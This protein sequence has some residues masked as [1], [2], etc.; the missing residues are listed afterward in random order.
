MFNKILH[1]FGFE[2]IMCGAN[3]RSEANYRQK[4]HIR[5]LVCNYAPLLFESKHIINWFL[6]RYTTKLF[7]HKIAFC[8]ATSHVL[9]LI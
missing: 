1:H 7:A 2:I 6:V 5:G 9:L 4:Q 3:L 8:Y